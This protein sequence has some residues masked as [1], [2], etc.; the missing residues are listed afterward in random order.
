M[1]HIKC[2]MHDLMIEVW[3]LSRSC[4]ILGIIA[5]LVQQIFRR[6]CVSEYCRFNVRSSDVII[7]L[8]RDEMRFFFIFSLT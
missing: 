5:F 8:K 6:T 7:A 3:R 1:G 4:E 2:S